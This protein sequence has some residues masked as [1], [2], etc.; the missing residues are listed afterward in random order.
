MPTTV[1]ITS[2]EHLSAFLTGDLRDALAFSGDDTVAALDVIKN[3]RPSLIALEDLYAVTARGRALIAR[4]EADPLLRGCQ[5]RI[6]TH[7]AAPPAQ[8]PIDRRRTPRFLVGDGVEV[9]FDGHRAVLVNVSLGGAQV[10][11]AR[12]LRPNQRGKVTLNTVNKGMRIPC[13]VAWA[14]LELVGGTPQ[15]RAGIEFNDPNTAALQAFIETAKKEES[16]TAILAINM[17]A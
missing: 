10:I 11:A 17:S 13:G 1:L 14:S 9:R 12:P 2:P 16:A 4:I 3:Q 7:M 6:L 8:E 15:Y 5:I